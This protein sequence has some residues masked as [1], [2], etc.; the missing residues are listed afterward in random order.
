MMLAALAIGFTVVGITSYQ[1]RVQKIA[2]SAAAAN[3][4]AIVGPPCPVLTKAEF[5]ALDMKPKKLFI[6]NEVNFARR[7]G[8]VECNVVS[9]GGGTGFA[10]I[11]QFSSPS[12]LS[13][14]TKDG[15]VTYFKPG[16]GKPV[17]VTTPGGKPKCMMAA[18]FNPT[19]G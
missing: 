6:F 5:D 3:A 1:N 2:E 16:T 18:N 13:V 15:A 19:G 9:D 14:T 17:T 12:L 11:C 4:A 10:P 8:H 7:F